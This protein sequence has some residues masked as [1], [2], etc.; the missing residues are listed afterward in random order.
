MKLIVHI[1]RDNLTAVEA[2]ELYDEIKAQ[3]A[4]KWPN[5]PDGTTNVGYLH[6]NGQVVDKF[7]GSDE[8][9]GPGEP[10]EI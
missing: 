8:P 7:L 6:V 9:G 1:T 2:S 4:E 10:G 3:L 5:N